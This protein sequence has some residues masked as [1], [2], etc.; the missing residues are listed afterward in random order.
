M[1]KPGGRN[2]VFFEQRGHCTAATPQC[3]PCAFYLWFSTECM[4]ALLGCKETVGMCCVWEGR[5]QSLIQ[6]SAGRVQQNSSRKWGNLNKPETS[7]HLISTTP[8][9]ALFLLKIK[10][11][12]FSSKVRKQCTRFLNSRGTVPIHALDPVSG[13]PSALDGVLS[14]WSVQS[15]V[16][17]RS[18]STYST[19]LLLLWSLSGIH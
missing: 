7:K 11:Q 15:T 16:I 6:V 8:C 5:A 12:I 14:D 4:Y 9:C 3:I 13:L 10:T 19:Q 1:Y 2:C 18:W 17:N